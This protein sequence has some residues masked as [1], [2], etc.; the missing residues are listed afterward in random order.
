[1]MLFYSANAQFKI[2]SD[3]KVSIHTTDLPFSPVSINCIGSTDYHLALEGEKNGLQCSADGMNTTSATYSGRFYSLLSSQHSSIGIRATGG[4]E[5]ATGQNNYSCHGI[6]GIAGGGKRNIGVLGMIKGSGGGA[7]VYGSIGGVDY[8]TP[9]LTDHN[10]YAGYFNGDTKITGNL[11]VQGTIHG[12]LLGESASENANVSISELRKTDNVTVSE[13]LSKV[14]VGSYNYAPKKKAPSISGFYE[15]DAKE[16]GDISDIQF[17]EVKENII[18]KQIKAKTHYNLSVDDL[19]AVFPDLVYENE[20]GERCINYIEVI[21]LLVQSINEL[22]S[23]I[24]ALTAQEPIIKSRSTSWT[25]NDLDQQLPAFTVKLSKLFQNTPNPFTE[26]TE[27]RFSLPDDV[28]NAYIY[29]F[30]MSGKMLRQV[31]VD[32]SMQRITINGYELSA[33]IYLYSLVVNGQEV[34]TKKM[35]LSK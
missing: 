5:F 15:M 8:G 17:T 2:H 1:M 28:Q 7:G 24:E 21:P 30:D 10:R 12:V 19:E 31:P 20:D 27:I 35:I 26:R 32:A 16:F 25:E 6:M 29:I 18:E 4:D 22:K 11:V 3:G 9:L 13:K 34:D 33:G 14:S 23:Q